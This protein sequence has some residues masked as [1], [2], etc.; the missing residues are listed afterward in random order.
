MEKELFIQEFLPLRSKLLRYA[1]QFLKAEEEAEDITQEVYVRLWSMGK[2]LYE[3]QNKSALSYTITKNLCINRLNA[4]QYS[5]EGLEFD[6]PYDADLPDRDLQN[7]DDAAHVVRII[8]NL[9]TLQQAILKMRHIDDLDISEIAELTGS[10]VEAVRVN[11][12]RGRKRVKELFLK[13]EN[14]GT[15]E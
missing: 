14:Y 13:R 12:S 8:E 9:P 6:V 10:S 11:L 15:K 7:K 2:T 3:Y 4:R 5:D 1:M